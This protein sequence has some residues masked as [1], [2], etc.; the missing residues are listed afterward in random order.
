MDIFHTWAPRK[1][2][3]FTSKGADE[4]TLR[5]YCFEAQTSSFREH[6]FRYTFTHSDPGVTPW[7]R[8]AWVSCTRRPPVRFRSRAR[9]CL[10]GVDVSVSRPPFRSLKINGKMPSSED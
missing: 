3:P 6:S 5:P 2:K 4:F 9:P 1:M 8:P 7:A 10:S